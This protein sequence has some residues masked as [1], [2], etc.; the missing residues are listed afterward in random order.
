MADPVPLLKS[1]SEVA[2][3]GL[4]GWFCQPKL[5]LVHDFRNG[6]PTDES[7]GTIRVAIQNSGKKIAKNII[8]ELRIYRPQGISSEN[9]LLFSRDRGDSEVLAGSGNWDGSGRLKPKCFRYRLKPHVSVDAR[10]PPLEIVDIAVRAAK[11][12]TPEDLDHEIEW[13]IYCAGVAPT[14]GQIAWSGLDLKR[15]LTKDLDE[16][17]SEVVHEVPSSTLPE[18]DQDGAE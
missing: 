10:R 3:Y 5:K 13:T 14:A 8:V 18:P 9:G 17:R 4:L 16:I 7:A 2:I 6:D 11:E 15:I 1:L 12:S